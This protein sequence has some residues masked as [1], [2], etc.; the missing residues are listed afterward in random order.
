M[1]IQ[2]TPT[3]DMVKRAEIKFKQMARRVAARQAIQLEF[4]KLLREKDFSFDD[5]CKEPLGIQKI[6]T[7]N[8]NQ[9]EYKG[10]RFNV[11]RQYVSDWVAR[12]RN[13]GYQLTQ[14]VSDYSE[15]SQ[16]RRQ[17]Y[18]AEQR[19][20]R[21]KVFNNELKCGEVLTVY[22]D[23]KEREVEVSKSS[24]WRILKRKLQDCIFSAVFL[25]MLLAHALTLT[26]VRAILRRPLSHALTLTNVRAILRRPLSHA[27]TLTRTLTKASRHRKLTSQA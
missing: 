18:E 21:D 12:V 2:E 3:D 4:L 20:I 14:V 15:S 8:I 27:L 22:S 11:S 19:R 7:A 24:V 17:F 16:N 10:E 13:N 6:V 9:I 26:N 1:I 5:T 25:N 23:K